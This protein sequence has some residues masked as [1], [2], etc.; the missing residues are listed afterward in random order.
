MPRSS[1]DECRGNGA[2]I[3]HVNALE[4]ALA[5]RVIHALTAASRDYGLR[6]QR[7]LAP[8]LP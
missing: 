6:L 2:K 7:Q 1:W 8:L 4:S 3:I 5:L